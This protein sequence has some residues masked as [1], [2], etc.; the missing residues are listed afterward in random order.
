MRVYRYRFLSERTTLK[1]ENSAK[2]KSK[3]II[4]IL[5]IFMLVDDV[6]RHQYPM[7]YIVP[8][9]YRAIYELE[10]S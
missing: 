7:L 2:G 3:P 1:I 4:R 10:C 5:Q 9:N 8:S 6:R